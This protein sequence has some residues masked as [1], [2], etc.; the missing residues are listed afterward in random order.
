MGTF[1][2]SNALSWN[3]DGSARQS[4]TSVG[5]QLVAAKAVTEC[6][7]LNG[8]RWWPCQ[9]RLHRAPQ[10]HQSSI[11]LSSGRS[12]FAR[13]PLPLLGQRETNVFMGCYCCGCRCSDNIVCVVSLE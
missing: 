5:W 3:F 10:L 1:R 7:S 8:G 12:P 9:L 4:S 13:L 2:S 6:S 11:D